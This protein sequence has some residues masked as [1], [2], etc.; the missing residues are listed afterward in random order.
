V[1]PQL[2]ALASELLKTADTLCPDGEADWFQRSPLAGRIYTDA[3]DECRKVVPYVVTRACK[4][5]VE[6][7]QRG[8]Q[9]SLMACLKRPGDETSPE[10]LPRYWGHDYTSASASIDGMHPCSLFRDTALKARDQYRRA[11]GENYGPGASQPGDAERES[12]KEAQTSGQARPDKRRGCPTEQLQDPDPKERSPVVQ[13]PVSP[14]A[15]APNSG[16]RAPAAVMP[17]P[18][19]AT[20]PTS[21]TPPPPLRRAPSSIP[22]VVAPVVPGERSEL[23]KGVTVRIQIYDG[24]QR[25]VVRTYRAPWQDMLASVPE[26][27]DVVEIA[28]RRNRPAPQQ[29]PKPT[30]RF[31]DDAAIVCARALGP[32]VGYSDWLVEPLSPNLKPTRRTVEVWIPTSASLPARK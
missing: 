4:G 1:A 16:G 32:Q 27:E 2:E 21:V 29:V 17:P 5:L 9:S 12:T 31:H 20:A 6:S 30:V 14:A 13:E 24:N 26:I 3:V 23:C 28:R 7:E 8:A 22:A 19:A 25:D 11:Y 10:P 18:P 15:S